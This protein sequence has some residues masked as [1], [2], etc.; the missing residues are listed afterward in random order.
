MAQAKS[1]AKGSSSKGAGNTRKRSAG[2]TGSKSS[3]NGSKAAS[4]K[5]T[6]SARSRSA[7]TPKR[8]RPQAASR[9]T[10]SSTRSRPTSRQRSTPRSRS[11]ANGA[12]SIETARSAIAGRTKDAGDDCARRRWRRH[13]R[14]RQGASAPAGRGSSLGRNPRRCRAQQRG[15]KTGGP[16]DAGHWAAGQAE[17][18]DPFAQ[19]EGQ[20]PFAGRRQCGQGHRC[21]WRADGKVRDRD[22]GD[23][24]GRGR[25]PSPIAN[26][27][28]APGTDCSPLRLETTKRRESPRGQ[29]PGVRQPLL[30]S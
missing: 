9:K 5:A 1:R 7:S 25:W 22:A 14:G 23:P 20:D 4:T 19:A 21:F 11:T 28:R 27:S 15:R 6:S 8:K 13:H 29:T 16:K 30:R 12:G 26:R 24:R 3:R 10:G 18:Q 2:S 17:G